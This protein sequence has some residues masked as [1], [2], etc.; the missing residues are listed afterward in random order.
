MTRP[1][2]LHVAVIGAGIVGVA[3][4][5]ELLRDGHRVTLVDP[6]PP[7]GE[8]AASYGNGGW[9]SPASVVPMSMPGLWRRV[10]GFLRDPL[11]PLAI[12]PNAVPG[13]APWL[14]GFVR[15]GSTVRRVERTARALASLLIDAPQRH[16]ALAREAGA[17]ELIE[18]RGLLYVFPDR[19]AFE[20]DALAWRLRRDNGVTWSELDR[21]SLHQQ[22]PALD[23]RYE[24]GVFIAAGAHCVD[25]GGYVAALARHAVDSGATWRQ[26]EATGLDIA[27]GRLTCVRTSQGPVPC[28]R[29]VIAAGFRSG[30]LARM[31]GDRVPLASER[32]YHVVIAGPAVAP[33]VPVMPS[34]GKMAYTMT[35][36]GLRVAGQVEFARPGAEPD[37][38]R[39]D[40]LMAHART[41]Y[42][43][44][45]MPG[46]PTRWMGNRPS[47]ADGLPVIGPAR[48]SAD[49]VHAFG[50]GHVGLAAGPVT[51]SL[52][53]DLVAGRTPSVALARFSARRFT[54]LP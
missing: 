46:Q 37:W 40:V 42:R 51:G 7:G 32:G 24:F 9:I 5:I 41:L 34:D 43:G 15:A 20:A 2:C 10:P 33:R 11:G 50:H 3:A 14:L 4:A 39:A 38:R 25:P 31:A 18:Q 49:I 35:P 53:A 45:A 44:L 21:D 6:G 19:A 22:E 23:R 28:D 52:V 47:I 29:A 1:A 54:M 8:Q 30:S 27:H 17:G 12:R 16:K 26:A 48:R 36:Q 13:L